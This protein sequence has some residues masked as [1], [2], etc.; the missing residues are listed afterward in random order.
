VRERWGWLDRAFSIEI[1]CGRRKEKGIDCF[2]YRERRE[3]W[4]P[5]CRVGQCG[6]GL[7]G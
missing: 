6:T 5:I 3:E 1:K 7:R 2:V 4:D